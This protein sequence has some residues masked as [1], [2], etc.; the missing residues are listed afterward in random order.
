ML[1]NLLI[2][3]IAIFNACGGVMLGWA[4]QR[5]Y[6]ESAFAG[7]VSHLTYAIAALFLVGLI[8][9]FIRAGKISTQLNIV[10]QGKYVGR[11]NG[12]KTLEKIAHL[13]DIANWLI[14]LGLLGTVIGFAIALSGVDQNGLASASGVQQA[15]SKLMEGMRVA[16][17][18]T[19]AGGFLGMWID[20]NRRMIRTAAVSLVED[21]T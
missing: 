20:I 18:T 6:V 9:C 10:K 1:R 13:S 7:D 3:R 17:T 11:V 2:Y 16:F 14:T 12:P 21:A 15:A 5:G 19:L 4:W 8:S